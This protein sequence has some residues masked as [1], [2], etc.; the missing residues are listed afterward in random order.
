MKKKFLLLL[1]FVA[2]LTSCNSDE[3]GSNVAKERKDIILSRAEEQLA[4]ESMDFAFRLFQQ[5]N[6]T[7]KKS[8][9]M[10]SPLSASRA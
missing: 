3:G 8:N 4:D 6:N 10:I 2:F 7:E 5:V 9:W 1:G